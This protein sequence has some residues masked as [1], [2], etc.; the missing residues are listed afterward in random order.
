M[1]FTL[2][3][4]LFAPTQRAKPFHKSVQKP[5]TE[6]S[7]VAHA[8]GKLSK[9]IADI[10]QRTKS[11]TPISTVIEEK[12]TV[13]ITLPKSPTPIAPVIVTEKDKPTKEVTIADSSTPS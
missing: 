8:V 12:P 9:R 7:G 1:S 2:L 10:E 11:P 3:D 4:D 6:Y 13:P 5:K